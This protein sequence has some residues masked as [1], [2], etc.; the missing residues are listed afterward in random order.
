MRGRGIGWRGLIRLDCGSIRVDYAYALMNF[1]YMALSALSVFCERI[2]G[3]VDWEV[4]VLRAGENVG[5]KCTMKTNTTEVPALYLL[6]LN[7]LT[8]YFK[9]SPKA[10]KRDIR[11]DAFRLSG[12]P[13]DGEPHA[14]CTL[15]RISDVHPSPSAVKR[16]MASPR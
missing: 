10:W 16:L 15:D 9:T 12:T 14:T 8:N 7:T 3:V 6:K 2:P 11:C 4:C 5:R 1:K 13:R